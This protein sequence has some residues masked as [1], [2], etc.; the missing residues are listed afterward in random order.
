MTPIVRVVLILVA[1]LLLVMA[2]RHVLFGQATAKDVTYK[3][4]ITEKQKLEIRTAQVAVYQAKE[5]L[6]QTPQFHSFMATQ[7]QMNEI[8]LRVQREAG[9]VPPKWQFTQGLECL[10]VPKQPEKK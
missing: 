5:V 2:F 9:C 3:P 10:E 1:F 8:S 4:V 7:N 6:E